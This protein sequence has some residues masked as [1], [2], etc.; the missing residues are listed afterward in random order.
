MPRTF[1][2]QA[3]QG[4]LMLRRV[5]TH[6]ELDK[7]PVVPRENGHLIIGHSETG[8][9]HVIEE[10]MGVRHCRSDNPLVN[11]LFVDDNCDGGFVTLTHLRAS[12][13]HEA[14]AI[15]PGVYEIRHQR[16]HTPEGWRQVND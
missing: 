9:H 4:E 12:D 10:M 5:S 7:L 14:L 3:A 2:N 6:P 8:H 1:N 13:T 11:Y 16:E 15:S